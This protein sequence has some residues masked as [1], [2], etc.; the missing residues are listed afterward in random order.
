VLFRSIQVMDGA[1]MQVS[2]RVYLNTYNDC[3]RNL[4][5]ANFVQVR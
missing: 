2:P 4:I 5:L 3:A 1:H